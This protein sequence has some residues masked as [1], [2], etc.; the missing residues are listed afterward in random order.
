VGQLVNAHFAHA[1]RAMVR[2]GMLAGHY[3]IK[4]V[5]SQAMLLL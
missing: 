5:D 4:K 1:S 2:M 3:P